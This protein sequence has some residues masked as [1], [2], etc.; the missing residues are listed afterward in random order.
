LQN[1]FSISRF[2]PWPHPSFSERRWNN[3]SIKYGPSPAPNILAPLYTTV[4]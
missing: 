2:Y 3:L 4:V 1:C